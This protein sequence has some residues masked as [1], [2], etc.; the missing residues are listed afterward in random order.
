MPS[1]A[2]MRAHPAPL[3]RSIVD[4]LSPEAVLTWIPNAVADDARIDVERGRVARPRILAQTVE[5]VVADERLGRVAVRIGWGDGGP[6]S[7]CE[8]GARRGP[9]RHAAALGLL[10][11]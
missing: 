8:C 10:L 1:G 6:S 3:L 9:C 5:S 11:V 4:L 7:E 2:R